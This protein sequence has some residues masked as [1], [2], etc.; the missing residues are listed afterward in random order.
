MI[1]EKFFCLLLFAAIIG[2]SLNSDLEAALVLESRFEIEE[3]EDSLGYLFLKVDA[4]EIHYSFWLQPLFEP[5]GGLRISGDDSV[6]TLQFGAGELRRFDFDSN[7]S[8][9][10]PENPFLR[11]VVSDEEPDW[12]SMNG[13]GGIE[14]N[15]LINPAFTAGMEY[16][17]SFED[18]EFAGF[19][20]NEIE[21]GLTATLGALSVRRIDGAI[22]SSTFRS[23]SGDLVR[24]EIIA[25]R[26]IVP[27][28]SAAVLA[29][30]A[31]VLFFAGGRRL[32][33]RS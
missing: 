8:V 20:E 28:P 17:G 29:V 16:S 5:P 3:R 7:G 32:V 13:G 23:V 25:G 1:W 33:R 27:E 26:A 30:G 15:R 11:N 4:S 6:R 22:V 14:V 24:S 2:V 12:I 18:P 10:L 31:A 9:R 21:T 19:F